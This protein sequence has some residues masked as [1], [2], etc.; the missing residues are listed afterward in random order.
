M[1]RNEQMMN[2]QTPKIKNTKEHG[3]YWSW[4][5]AVIE[6]VQ[7]MRNMKTRYLPHF[8]YINGQTLVD[9]FLFTTSGP[10]CVNYFVPEFQEWMDVWGIGP[11]EFLPILF[12]RRNNINEVMD[13]IAM[14]FKSRRRVSVILDMRNLAFR[15]NSGKSEYIRKNL[16]K[17]R[18]D[19]RKWW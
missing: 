7:G 11:W 1:I 10:I 16:V 14:I 15:A 18:N 6:R 8:K 5:K 4:R 19:T 2:V 12:S 17:F 3:K 9:R 13:L